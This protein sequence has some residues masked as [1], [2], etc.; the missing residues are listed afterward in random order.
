[1]LKYIAIIGEGKMG[2]NLLYYLLDMDFNLVWIC[3]PEADLEKLSRTLTRRLGRSLEAGIIDDT[4]HQDILDRIK[5]SNNL[6]DVASCDLVIEAIS[7]NI[8]AKKLL[9]SRLDG[10]AP[11]ACIFTSNSSSITPSSL[12]PSVSRKDK[13]TGLHFFYPIALKDIAEVITTPETSVETLKK[14]TSFLET[15]SRNYIILDEKNSFILNR[16]FL[17][18]QNEAFLLVNDNKAS[19]QQIDRIVRDHFFPTGVFEFFDSVG[20]DI[21]LASVIN[22]SR[23][24]IAEERYF[25]LILRLQ[26]HVSEGRLGA[27]TKAGFYDESTLQHPGY[28]ENDSLI[29]ARLKGSYE[30]AFRR[31]RLLSGIPSGKLKSAMDEYFGAET[32]VVS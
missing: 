25:P 8:E 29:I 3:S 6:D 5:I 32:P 22:Y 26:E 31:F 28:P 19:I 16:I 17:Q 7:E 18:F 27:K 12:V 24:D 9:F 15:I 1:M 21:M 14:I 2:T 10:I 11:P 30:A 13:F 23:N 20:L 4:R